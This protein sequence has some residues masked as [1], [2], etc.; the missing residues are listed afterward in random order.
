MLGLG[1]GLGLAQRKPGGIFSPAVL[2]ANGAEGIWIDPADVSTLFQDAAGTMPVTA[3][4]DPVQLVLDKSKGQLRGSNVYTG[5]ALGRAGNIVSE[6]ENQ[7]RSQADSN[8]DP[9]VFTQ[10]TGL[11]I[12]EW[13]E[14]TGIFNTS[15]T[16]GMFRIST[17]DQMGNG[18][19]LQVSGVAGGGH[20]R[21]LWKATVTTAYVGFAAVGT[22]GDSFVSISDAQFRSLAGNHITAPSAEGRPTYQVGGGYHWL[23]LGG[24]AD[25]LEGP[26]PGVG[27]DHLAVGGFRPLGVSNGNDSTFSIDASNDYQMNAGSGTQYFGK[28]TAANLGVG[29]LNNGS[30]L[31][32][33]DIVQRLSL[34]GSTGQAEL[35]YNGT[36]AASSTTYNGQISSSQTLRIGANRAGVN[37]LGC[38]FYGLVMVSDASDPVPLERWMAQKFGATL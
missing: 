27:P 5:A 29:T 21:A 20:F 14:F 22:V 3:A 4:G 32:G 30:D 13:Y 8:P 23:Q 34:A 38:R 12:G 25:V 28:C 9:A 26:L 1:L 33:Q 17:S 19:L 35:A 36:V 7:I 2:F 15:E 24:D 16:A 37:F 31:L 18:D 11:T 10:V 6:F